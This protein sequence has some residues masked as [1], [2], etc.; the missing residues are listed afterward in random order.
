VVVL[1]H[2]T[3]QRVL[4]TGSAGFIGFH[5]ARTLLE[6]GAQVVGVDALTDYYDVK[7]KEGRLALLNAFPHYSHFTQRL[8]DAEG[9]AEIISASRP[10]VVVHLAAQAGVR[11]A[12]EEP[13]SYVESNIVGSFNVLDAVREFRVNHLLLA[14]TSSVYG[15]NTSYPYVEAQR[16]DHPLSFYSATKKAVEDMA[17]SY[18][19]L[20]QIPTT[21]F[22]F[23]TVYGSWGRPDMALF[24]FV[25]AARSGGTIRV[26][27]Q[28][29]M[30]R[31]FTHV[32]DLVTAIRALIEAVPQ[33][34][35]PI[36]DHDSLAPSAPYRVVNIGGGSPISVLRLIEAVESATGRSLARE[37]VPAVPGEV[38]VTHADARL[39]KELTGFVPAVGI[40]EGVREFVAWYDSWTRITK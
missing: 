9:L 23:F 13:R 22:R 14:S 6:H 30:K 26:H 10:T 35:K 15:A 11:Y 27:D 18:S 17:H 37:F 36:S 21:S 1:S 34:G 4:V 40:D 3:V 19:H 25:D 7:L 39:L 20:H 8:E 2:P 5:L 38:P 28:G 33:V 29:Q 32:S 16:T 31:D 24:K 12:L